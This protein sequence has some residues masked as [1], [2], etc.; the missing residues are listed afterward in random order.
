M[1]TLNKN[2]IT[3]E[4]DDIYKSGRGFGKR[5]KNQKPIDDN[6]DSDDEDG[7]N[8]ANKKANKTRKA[9]S[10]IPTVTFKKT[11]KNPK[12]EAEKAARKAAKKE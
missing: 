6:E 12:T 8:L 7:R 9:N 5:I 2:A 10:E 11:I 3:G 4:A 1:A